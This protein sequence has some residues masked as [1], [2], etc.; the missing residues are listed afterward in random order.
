MGKRGWMSGITVLLLV[1]SLA[2]AEGPSGRYRLAPNQSW[3]ADLRVETLAVQT[4][5]GYQTVRTQRIE[6]GYRMTA[7]EVDR[8]GAV[9]VEFQCERVTVAERTPFETLE[10]DAAQNREG[11]PERFAGILDTAGRSFRLTCDA[12]GV[13][14]D[15][16]FQAKPIG[17][18]TVVERHSWWGAGTAHAVAGLINIPQTVPLA[19]NQTWKRTLLLPSDAEPLSAEVTFEVYQIKEGTAYLRI[20]GPVDKQFSGKYE[21]DS[22]KFKGEILFH[23][24][25]TV[26]GE[27]ELDIASG[28]ARKATVIAP[29]TGEVRRLDAVIPLTLEWKTTWEM[30]PAEN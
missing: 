14:P 13:T 24:A 25:G 12:K 19:L 21:L 29:L 15:L 5:Q 20:L 3:L 26:R 1:G 9:K 11:A 2:A 7:V 4:I 23:L 6:S 16:R 18:G 10:L 30:R 28:L 17:S 22:G 8:L 27:V